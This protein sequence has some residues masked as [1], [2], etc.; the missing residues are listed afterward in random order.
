M[1]AK[2]RPLFE[3]VLQERKLPGFGAFVV[4]STGKLLLNEAVG[5]VNRD[6]GTSA[7]FTADT[8]LPLY[9]CT[10]LVTSIAAL[11][12]VEQ[13][14]MLLSDTVEKY[15]PQISEIQLLE[16]ITQ[17]ADGKAP[18]IK[19]SKPTSTPTIHQLLTHTGGFS[20]DFFHAPTLQWRASTG[21]DPCLYHAVGAWQDFKT[22][23]V[24]Q[25]GSKYIYGVNTDW[26]GFVVQAV[27]GTRLPEYIDDHVLKPLGMT[28]SGAFLDKSKPRLVTHLRLNGIDLVA[29]PAAANQES[30]EV[31]GG[32]GFLYSTM[33]DYAKLLSTL[34]NQGTSP[35]TGATI[36]QPSSVQKYLFTD[37]LG[38]EVDKSALGEI[39]TAIPLLSNEGTF[40]PSL[41]V[42]AKGWSYGLLMNHED[43]PHGR[44]KGS[45]AWAGL[46]NLYYWIDPASGIAGMVVTNILPFMDRSILYLLDQVERVA[47]GHDIVPESKATGNH[48][49]GAVVEAKL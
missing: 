23:F 28:A 19:W 35:S 37:Q 10:K 17:S 44:K 20:Y 1:D 6:D 45:G 42:E 33:N 9:S 41:P 7:G 21:R 25:P 5:K 18:D 49:A 22:P 32:G 14:K 26:L 12:L 3:T 43:L 30:P 8:I 40:F 29:N 34:L 48:V 11:Q 46:G 24:A 27:T 47:Y 39:P 38:P 31:F 36:L 13:G 2:I 16:S 15:V 4:D